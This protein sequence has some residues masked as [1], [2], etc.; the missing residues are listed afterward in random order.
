MA[1]PKHF[2][3]R[4]Y[5]KQKRSQELVEALVEAT[6]RVFL[7]R[8]YDEM[9]LSHVAERAGVSVGSLYQ[10]FPHKEALL[11]ALIERQS[12]AEEAFIAARFAL[13]LEKGEAPRPATLIAEAVHALVDFRTL[14]APLQEKLLALLPVIGAYYD[15]R[16]RG[17]EIARQFRQMLEGFFHPA[18]EGPGLDEIVFM[19][20]NTTHAVT[21]DNLVPK[22][23]EFDAPRMRQELVR[24]LTA[25]LA[26]LPGDPFR[27]H[28]AVPLTGALPQGASR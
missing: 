27:M 4:K 18:P 9:S 3:P 21:H 5:P 11:V 17:R 28:A 20:A 10:Y 6:A 13:W 14:H 2:Q 1:V 7:E 23:L 19:I 22:P 24:L 16:A 15:L 8:G 12:A 25:Y 26:A